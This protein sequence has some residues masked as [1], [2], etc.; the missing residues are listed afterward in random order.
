MLVSYAVSLSANIHCKY[1]A[2][3][4]PIIIKVIVPIIIAN[5]VAVDANIGIVTT[6]GRANVAMK[7]AI[8]A[9]I[10][11]INDNIS[12][13]MNAAVAMTFQSD[14]TLDTIYF[15]TVLNRFVKVFKL[16]PLCFR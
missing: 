1:Q 10:T 13:N 12:L 2:I 3:F 4:R 6:N 16:S 14:L 5:D 7:I 15:A 11:I 8:L 9:K